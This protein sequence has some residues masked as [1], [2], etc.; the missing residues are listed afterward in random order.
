[1]ERFIY[2]SSYNNKIRKQDLFTFLS[3]QVKQI[4]SAK[5]E[6]DQ[7]R[8]DYSFP[9]SIMTKNCSSRYPVAVQ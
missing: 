6:I 5:K 9:S 1:V 7:I 4:I 2:L 8:N 3:L